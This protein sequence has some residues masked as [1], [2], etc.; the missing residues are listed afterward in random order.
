MLHRKQSIVDHLVAANGFPIR[1]K[2]TL[3]FKNSPHQWDSTSVGNTEVST[4]TMLTI[5]RHG[6]SI[7]VF[8]QS[9]QCWYFVDSK[10]T[11]SKF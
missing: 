8:L 10:H 1:S 3:V 11:S 2:A 7:A 4:L 6:N 5:S 9:T